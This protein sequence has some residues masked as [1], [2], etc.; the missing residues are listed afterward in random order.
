MKHSSQ[1]TV[2]YD[3]GSLWGREAD[4]ILIRYGIAASS[5][6]QRGEGLLEV[7]QNNNDNDKNNNKTTRLSN[8]EW[9]GSWACV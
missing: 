7:I 8:Y 9:K 5:S 1:G 6:Y 2:A 4:V 3:V